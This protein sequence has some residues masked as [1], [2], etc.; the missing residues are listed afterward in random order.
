MTAPIAEDLCAH[1]GA[2]HQAAC[3]CSCLHGHTYMVVPNSSLSE[4]M[5]LQTGL[6]CTPSH[7]WCGDAHHHA[8]SRLGDCDHNTWIAPYGAGSSRTGG[9]ASHIRL[10]VTGIEMSSPGQWC[11]SLPKGQLSWLTS[12]SPLGQSP[13]VIRAILA[14]ANNARQHFILPAFPL[15]PTYKNDCKVQRVMDITP[16]HFDTT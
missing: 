14:T 12:C 8:D 3:T 5:V 4:C 16:G 11:M 13:A 9:Q 15:R 7:A 10:I 6:C 1:T 2:W